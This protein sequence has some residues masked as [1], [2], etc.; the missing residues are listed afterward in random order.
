MFA[1]VAG[2]LV[3]ADNGGTNVFGATPES[4]VKKGDVALKGPIGEKE[5]GAVSVKVLY[6][7]LVL[8]DGTVHVHYTPDRSLETHF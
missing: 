5:A 6:S 7:E 2:K 1:V 8:S 3:L 4:G